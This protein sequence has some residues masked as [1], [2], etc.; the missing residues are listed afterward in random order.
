MK[1]GGE[2]RESVQGQFDLLG[3][4][5]TGVAPGGVDIE[6]AHDA[7]LKTKDF[8]VTDANVTVVLDTGPTFLITK[9]TRVGDPPELNVESGTISLKLEGQVSIEL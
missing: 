5:V 2:V 6:V 1:Y 7:A 8:D 4:K 9:A 3:F